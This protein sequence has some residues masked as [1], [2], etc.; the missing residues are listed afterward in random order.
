MYLNYLGGKK[1]REVLECNFDGVHNMCRMNQY[2]SMSVSSAEEQPPSK[3]KSQSQSQL[4]W[5]TK[6]SFLSTW[7]SLLILFMNVANTV[8]EDKIKIQ[9]LQNNV[10]SISLSNT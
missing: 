9:M 3:Q 8:P 5:T 10:F 7:S 2:K 1:L 6:A 4:E